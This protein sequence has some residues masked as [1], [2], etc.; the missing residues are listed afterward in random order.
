M[1]LT[2]VI[3]QWS[4]QA[5]LEGFG[6]EGRRRGR[7]LLLDV[8]GVT[9][10][11]GGHPVARAAVDAMPADAGE[12]TELVTGGDCGPARAAWLNGIAAHVLDYDDSA[13][14]SMVGHP[15]AVIWPAVWAW[16]DADD[17]SRMLGFLVGIETM[18]RLAAAYG[19]GDAAYGKG[20]HTTTILGVIGATAG[21]SVVAGLN[22]HAAAGAL[23]MAAGLASGLRASFGTPAKAVQ[24]GHAAASAVQSVLLAQQGLLGSPDALGARG[25]AGA[26]WGEAIDEHTLAQRFLDPP[27][28]E[29]LGEQPQPLTAETPLLAYPGV[30]I[31]PYAACRGT[32]RSI[33][34]AVLLR[35]ELDERVHRIAGVEL[36]MPAETYDFLA[37]TDPATGLEAK[38]SVPYAVSAALLDGR[39][40]LAQFEDDRVAAA[41]IRSL[42][43]RV[44]CL[45]PAAAPTWREPFSP[46]EV[47]VVLDDGTRL[48]RV[49]EVERGHPSRPLSRPQLLQKFEECLE[50]RFGAAGRAAA[51][52]IAGDLLGPGD[53]ET[54]PAA[55]GAITRL[56]SMAAEQ[57]LT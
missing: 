10:A 42:L 14:G 12:A 28:E 16:Q 56:A 33:E 17:E 11:G 1:R 3:A 27:R 5:T 13:V 31:K 36:R 24:V 46:D 45:P 7:E 51:A 43:T 40:G 44:S 23:G 47:T 38:F 4:G 6:D 18:M 34:A 54:V 19:G 39:G 49:I 55:V 2:E 25:L 35:E 48:T 52:T 32:H 41:D 20:L 21:L 53:A 22:Q 8:I 30:R 37:S 50:H 26:L 9:V 15:S 29:G 57:S